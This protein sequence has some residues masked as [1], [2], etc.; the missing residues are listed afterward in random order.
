MKGLI[1]PVFLLKFFNV[2]FVTNFSFT[3]LRS[4]N[5]A[6]VNFGGVSIFGVFGM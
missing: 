6:E 4:V 2:F 1:V 5:K 3:L